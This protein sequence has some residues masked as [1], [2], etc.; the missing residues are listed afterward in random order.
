MSS[1]G[2]NIGISNYPSA[3]LSG[4]YHGSVL[5]VLCG[6][7][8]ESAVMGYVLFEIYKIT[9]YTL[10]WSVLMVLS[11]F[12]TVRTFTL[13]PVSIFPYPVPLGYQVDSKFCNAVPKPIS[14]IVKRRSS[15]VERLTKKDLD[16][17]TRSV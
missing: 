16:Q 1:T 3:N 8:E 10:I 9:S 12:I 17:L 4:K 14:N 11:S 7:F 2:L 6:M 15:V 5:S 13:M